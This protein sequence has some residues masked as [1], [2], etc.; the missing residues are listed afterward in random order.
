MAVA[1]IY[2]FFNNWMAAVVAA[3]AWA[4][5]VP[6]EI[7]GSTLKMCGQDAFHEVIL[8][9]NAE[10]L[11]A[12]YISLSVFAVIVIILSFLNLKQ[13]GI[14]L[15][16]EMI[17]F[18]VTVLLMVAYCIG[19]LSMRGADACDEL[20]YGN[21][22]VAEDIILESE[23]FNFVGWLANIQVFAF[24]LCHQT[25]LPSLIEPVKPK[26]YLHVFLL[27]TLVII[28]SIYILVGVVLSLWFGAATQ[29]IVT[30]NWVSEI[31]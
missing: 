29:E 24:S 4:S 1:C 27:V 19:R 18:L 3:S 31:Y 11:N 16:F 23:T 14:F 13:Q 28:M 8:P 17:F 6:F 20:G 5:N 2:E 26:K 7:I 21:R 15:F 25:A 22:T 12:Y 9:T 30:L 10:C